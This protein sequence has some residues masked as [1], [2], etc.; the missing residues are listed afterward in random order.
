V[1]REHIARAATDTP[2][3]EHDLRKQDIVRTDRQN[4][5]V[6]VR[7]CSPR[8]RAAIAAWGAKEDQDVKGTVAWLE[9]IHLYLLAF[10]GRKVTMS[11]R[12]ELL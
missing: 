8:T 1:P 12:F 2:A 3:S 11:R 5:E 6:V 9:I 10:F 4:F 7:A